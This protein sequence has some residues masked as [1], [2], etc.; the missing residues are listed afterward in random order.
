[1]RGEARENILSGLRDRPEWVLLSGITCNDRGDRGK[2]GAGD[3]ERMV[4]RR[5][6]V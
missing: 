3:A 6:D 4:K 1:M 5:V 2:K